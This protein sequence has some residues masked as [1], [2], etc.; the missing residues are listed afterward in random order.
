MIIFGTRGLESVRD[1]GT[2]NCPRCGMSKPY[3]LKSVKRW[4]TL[5]F[6]PVIPIG[7]AGSYVECAQCGGTYSEEVFA[8]DPEGEARQVFLKLRGLLVLVMLADGQAD[9]AEVRAICDIY[10]EMTDEP[11]E[12]QTVH[13]DIRRARQ[14]GS[15]LDD[16]ARQVAADLTFKGKGTFLNAAF[17]VLSAKGQLRH[18]GEEVISR[19]AR[20]MSVSPEQLKGMIGE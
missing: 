10:H 15:N 7:S 4:F 17:R 6:I 3:R 19:L 16:F 8:Y 14:T 11:L 2:F 18:D 9:P 20:C 1:T 5:Y 12:E 13:E